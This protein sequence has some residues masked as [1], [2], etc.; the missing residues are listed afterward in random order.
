MEE[1][2][3][4]T[5]LTHLELPNS[6]TYFWGEG[7]GEGGRL[8]LQ[9]PFGGLTA[10][11]TLDMSMDAGYQRKIQC[12][13][14][15]YLEPWTFCLRELPASL[16]RLDLSGA[17]CDFDGISRLTA[18]R[19]LHLKNATTECGLVP[20]EELAG[21]QELRVLSLRD[22]DSVPDDR[23]PLLPL[24][25]RLD[26]LDLVG[27]H[28]YSAEAGDERTD[29]QDTADAVAYCRLGMWL[30]VTTDDD[31]DGDKLIPV[32]HFHRRV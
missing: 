19:E 30:Q 7:E 4:M 16:R 20:L 21:L 27:A 6:F 15:L 12:L 24:V 11:E 5:G 8:K 31:G 10:L 23:S 9:L 1:L 18:L 13:K 14:R 17:S 22:C 26:E 25:A 3:R 29:E 2:G 32:M 28:E